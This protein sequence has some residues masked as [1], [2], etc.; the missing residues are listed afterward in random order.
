M[1]LEI[2][3]CTLL[4]G[5]CAAGPV[6]GVYVRP[7]PERPFQTFEACRDAGEP[8]AAL[9]LA[10]HPMLAQAWRY[11]GSRCTEGAEERLNRP[12]QQV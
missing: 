5:H 3:F 9:F 4:A 6:H 11:V 1:T 2:F 12:D 7:D 8:A 10:T